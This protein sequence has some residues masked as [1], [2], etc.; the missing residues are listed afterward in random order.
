MAFA[1]ANTVYIRGNRFLRAGRNGVACWD[2]YTTSGCDYQSAAHFSCR[3]IYPRW[4]LSDPTTA[5]H[6]ASWSWRSALAGWDLMCRTR[7]VRPQESVLRTTRIRYQDRTIAL[8][9][10]RWRRMETM[11]VII[12][13]TTR[14]MKKTIQN[15]YGQQHLQLVKAVIYSC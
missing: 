2:R 12:P 6:R 1:T 10:R 11:A 9:S 5:W 4:I 3:W 8:P 14:K 15:H 7:S 13:S